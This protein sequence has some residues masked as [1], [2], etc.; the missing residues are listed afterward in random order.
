MKKKYLVHFKRNDIMV[1]TPDI[2]RREQERLQDLMREQI[3]IRVNMSRTM[4]NIWLEFHINSREELVEIVKTL[5]MCK[6]L[7]FEIFEII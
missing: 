6:N 2:L 7:F 1:F 4:D 3:L 5:P